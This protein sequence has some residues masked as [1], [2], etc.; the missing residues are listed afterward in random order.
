MLEN[1]H[2]VSQIEQCWVVTSNDVATDLLELSEFIAESERP[3]ATAQLKRV[4][5][6]LQAVEELQTKRRRKSGQHKHERRS[7]KQYCDVQSWRMLSS[8]HW[9]LCQ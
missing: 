6:M 9:R 8:W 5:N 7:G 3:V 1:H 4:G 2:L